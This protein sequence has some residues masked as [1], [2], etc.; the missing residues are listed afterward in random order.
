MSRGQQLEGEKLEGEKLGEQLE[1]EKAELPRGEQPEGEKAGL[2]LP[3]PKRAKVDGQMTRAAF[4]EAVRPLELS[5][6]VPAKFFRTGSSG[7]YL[8]KSVPVDVGGQTVQVAVQCCCVV[9]GSKAWG[10]G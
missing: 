5:V 4:A 9:K 8:S 2:Q 10:P 1:G 6:A 7:W 3:D